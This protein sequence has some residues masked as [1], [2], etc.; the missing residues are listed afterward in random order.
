M[1][2]SREKE[3]LLKRTPTK[4]GISLQGKDLAASGAAAGQNLAAVAGGHSLAE[5]V[6]LASLTLLGLVSSQHLCSLLRFGVLVTALPMD[7]AGPCN[8]ALYLSL[9][10][11]VKAKARSFSGKIPVPPPSLFFH[12]RYGILHRRA[13]PDGGGIFFF[14]PGVSFFSL[15]LYK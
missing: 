11:P 8:I 15:S 4:V 6:D 13:P 1:L 2:S 12:T 5:A 10:R 9:Q 3:A 7:R 14:P